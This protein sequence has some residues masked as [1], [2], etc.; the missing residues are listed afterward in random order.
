MRVQRPANLETTSLGAA[1]AA[2]IGAGIWTEE[3]VL[4]RDHS[5]AGRGEDNGDASVDDVTDFDP[6]AE[7]ADVEARYARWKKAVAKSLDQDDLD[8]ET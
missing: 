7:G 6:A 3:W 1:F 2:G 8:G 4:S 5:E